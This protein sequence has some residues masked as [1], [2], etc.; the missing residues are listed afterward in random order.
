MYHVFLG[1]GSNVGDRLDHLGEAAREIGILMNIVAMSSI[2]ETEPVEMPGV[3]MF[4][5]MVIEVGTM[6]TPV[7]LFQEI[8]AIE[9]KMGRKPATHLKPRTI[10]I[11]I[12]MYEEFSYTDSIIQIPHASMHR[13]RFVLVP[14]REIAPAMKHQI[15]LRTVSELLDE[16]ADRSEVF[17]TSHQLPIPIHHMNR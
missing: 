2:Y 16:C 8:K 3:E 6:L 7:P 9:D 17:R 4:L 5:N 1:L 13:R 11:D 15:L 10:D 14:L 12:L